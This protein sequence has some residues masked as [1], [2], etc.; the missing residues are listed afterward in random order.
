MHVSIFEYMRLVIGTS[1]PGTL[2][3]RGRRLM[4][5]NN[6]CQSEGNAQ[7]L[8]M[9]A[10]LYFRVHETGGWDLFPWSPDRARAE[11]NGVE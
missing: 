3:G 5:L 11:T 1:S 8:P 6:G 10:C 4:G 9:H 7:G 2:T